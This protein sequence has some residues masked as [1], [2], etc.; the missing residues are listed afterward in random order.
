KLPELN[1]TTCIGLIG[2]EML[3]IYTALFPEFATSRVA[4]VIANPEGIFK[5]APLNSPICTGTIGFVIL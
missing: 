2:L 4:P 5:F 1:C 3:Y